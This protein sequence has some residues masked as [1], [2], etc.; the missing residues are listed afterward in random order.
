MKMPSMS[1][2]KNTSAAA[3]DTQVKSKDDHDD[4]EEDEAPRGRVKKSAGMSQ[5]F[6]TDSTKNDTSK[7]ALPPRSFAPI[8]TGSTTRKDPT[9]KSG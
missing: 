2:T 1:S 4:S 5:S 6:V 7:M 3:Q 9:K 8:L